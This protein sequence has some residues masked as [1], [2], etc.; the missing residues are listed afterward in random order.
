MSPYRSRQR[1]PAE[2][3]LSPNREFSGTCASGERVPIDGG[4]ELML[5]PIRPDD[6]PALIRAFGRMTPDQVRSR[7]FH[8]M[9]ELPES[10]AR[11]MCRVDP[12][13]TIALVLVDADGVEIRGEGRVHLDPVTECAEFALAV[14]PAFTGK[15]LG[16]LLVTR[17]AEACRAAGMR[18]VWG[19]TQAENDPMLA[20]ARHLGFTL[21]RQN[22]DAGLVS[23]SLELPSPH[24]SSEA[25]AA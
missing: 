7:V 11:W 15:G 12:D 23:M 10:I 3:R 16:R 4:P 17:L 24:A 13:A 21:R 19:D 14:D 9:T 20:L 18:E 1:V 6:A 25:D 22:Q 5:R 2:L 8:A